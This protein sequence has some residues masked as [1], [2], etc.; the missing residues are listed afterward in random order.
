LLKIKQNK[1]NKKRRWNMKT[2]QEVSSEFYFYLSDGRVL[3]SMMELADALDNMEE[4]VFSH[5][6]GTENND[7]SNWIR[8]VFQNETL[9]E[10]IKQKTQKAMAKNIRSEIEKEIKK[11][12]KEKKAKEKE[13]RKQAK[14]FPEKVKKIKAPKKKTNILNLLKNSQ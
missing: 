3:K 7:F 10:S 1:L 9:S 6:V 11:E 2:N 4:W 12:E 8:D 14:E 13:M 5:H